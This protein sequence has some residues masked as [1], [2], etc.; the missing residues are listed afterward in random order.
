MFR[1]RRTE[2][3]TVRDPGGESSYPLRFQIADSAWAAQDRVK[4]GVGRGFERIALPVQERVV[5]PIEDRAA[6]AGAPAR[7]LSF[8]AVVALAAAAGVAALLWAAPDSPDRALSPSAATAP[9]PLAAVRQAPDA[10]GGPTLH[11]VPP[12]FRAAAGKGAAK[13]DSA[14][15]VE[16]A[17]APADPTATAASSEKVASTASAPSAQS[18]AVAGRPA[19]PAAISVAH[20]FA[21][22]FVLYETGEAGSEVRQAFRETATPELSHAL[23]R[24]PPRLPA[25]VTVPRAKVLNVVAAPSHGRSFPVSVSLLRVGVTSELRLVMEQLKANQWRVTNVLG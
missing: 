13:L 8:G 24:R 12:V 22:A 16:P 11:G 21:N 19:G 17:A 23:L 2:T 9:Q 7:A 10:A 6:D 15:T 14:R 3:N 5:W 18:S 20:D 4:V 1:Q 25:N